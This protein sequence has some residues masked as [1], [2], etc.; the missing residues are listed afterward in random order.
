MLTNILVCQL[1]QRTSRFRT[2]VTLY[3]RPFDSAIS[4]PSVLIPSFVQCEHRI[5]IAVQA[6]R[7]QIATDFECQLVALCWKDG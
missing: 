3:R 6:N 1:R 5:L 4:S 7:K 2:V